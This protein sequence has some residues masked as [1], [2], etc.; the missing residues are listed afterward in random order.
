V[1]CR[2]TPSASARPA[3]T[4]TLGRLRVLLDRVERTAVAPARHVRDGLAAGVERSGIGL[5]QL[6]R[7]ELRRCARRPYNLNYYWPPRLGSGSARETRE[8]AR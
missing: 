4:T 2:P 8:L 1:R 3:T 5:T 7:G 6:G